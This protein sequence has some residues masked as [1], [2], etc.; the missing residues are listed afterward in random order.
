MWPATARPPGGHEP[1][2]Q[3]HAHGGAPRDDRGKGIESAHPKNRGGRSRRRSRVGAAP[4]G[5]RS[6]T[7]PN[8]TRKIL[9]FFGF[10]SYLLRVP[11]HVAVLIN[12]NKG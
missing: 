6:V 12:Q 4:S 11:S 9:V 10:S 3:E 5:K 8:S 2:Q 7:K 1:A